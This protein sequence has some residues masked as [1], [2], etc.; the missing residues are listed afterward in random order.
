MSVCS[1]ELLLTLLHPATILPP[2]MKTSLP[3]ALSMSAALSRCQVRTRE[4]RAVKLVMRGTTGYWPAC[5]DGQP[6]R[7]AVPSEG[8]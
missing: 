1:M 8:T 5:S 2:S 3:L 7:P 4:A 6:M